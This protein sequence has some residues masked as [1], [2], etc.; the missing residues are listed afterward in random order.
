MTVRIYATDKGTLATD[1][2]GNL[3]DPKTLQLTGEAIYE[4][5]EKKLVPSSRQYAP[6]EITRIHNKFDLRY[7]QAQLVNPNPSQAC[8]LVGRFD[9]PVTIQIVKEVSD[10][11]FNR[12]TSQLAFA[13]NAYT[14]RIG[15]IELIYQQNVAALHAQAARLLE[16][17]N[18]ALA[19]LQ[20]PSLEMLL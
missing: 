16:Q 12:I 15:E 3:L 20:L 13:Q 14:A 4:E 18:S 7:H 11:D 9:M 10:E 5:D 17:K 19:V 1:D 6:G 2:R 8:D